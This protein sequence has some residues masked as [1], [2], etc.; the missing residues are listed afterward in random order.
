M[1]SSVDVKRLMMSL[2]FIAFLTQT[3]TS[4]ILENILYICKL[5]G[6]HLIC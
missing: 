1:S 5:L 2:L 6:K 4:E 3:V